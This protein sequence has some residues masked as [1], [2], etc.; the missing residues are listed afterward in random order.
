MSLGVLPL[1]DIRVTVGTLP[2]A[3]SVFQ[4]L[5]PLAIVSFI[6]CPSVEP[7]A[8][9]LAPL[10]LAL[11]SVAIFVILESDAVPMVVVPVSLIDPAVHVLHNSIPLP[12]QALILSSIQTLRKTLDAEVVQ[13]LKLLIGH[14]L[15]E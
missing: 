8:I 14:A 13:T 12:L 3:V 11:V 2:H 4:T 9:S 5:H 15:A 1:T 6:V 7:L 10:E